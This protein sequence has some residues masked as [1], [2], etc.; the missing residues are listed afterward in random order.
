MTAGGASR[1]LLWL[2]VSLRSSNKGI[3]VALKDE[4]LARRELREMMLWMSR[5]VDLPNAEVLPAE[6]GCPCLPNML[7]K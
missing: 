3:D 7:A 2:R 1:S 4:R 6:I 5:P